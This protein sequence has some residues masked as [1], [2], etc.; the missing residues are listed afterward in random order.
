MVGELCEK[1]HLNVP[2]LGGTILY[3]IDSSKT[4]TDMYDIELLTIVEKVGSNSPKC[5]GK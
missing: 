5:Q 2:V 3:T 1:G 4:R